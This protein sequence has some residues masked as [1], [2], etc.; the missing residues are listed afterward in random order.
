MC[1]VPTSMPQVASDPRW[2]EAIVCVKDE[3]ECWSGVE[4]PYVLY[5][6]AMLSTRYNVLGAFLHRKARMRD[7]SQSMCDD[8]GRWRRGIEH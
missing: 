7:A 2:N 4:R 6:T 8:Q 5:C 3:L 1:D